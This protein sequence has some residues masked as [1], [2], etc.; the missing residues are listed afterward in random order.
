MSDTPETDAMIWCFGNDDEFVKAHVTRRLERERDKLK[1][2]NAELVEC[3]IAVNQSFPDLADFQD[4][5]GYSLDWLD[6]K[7]SA[8]LSKAKE[9][10]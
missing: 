3:L 10:K 8:A 5:N 6:E 1:A 9:A 2:I 4:K 7:L